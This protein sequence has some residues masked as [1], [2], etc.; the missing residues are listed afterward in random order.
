MSIRTSFF[1]EARRLS[2]EDALPVVYKEVDLRENPDHPDHRFNLTVSPGEVVA[3]IGDEDSGVGDLGK[4]TLG[5]DHPPSGRVVVFGRNMATLSYDDLLLFRRQ[6]G[7]LQVGDGLLQNLTLKDNVALPLRYA[8]DHRMSEVHER[9]EALVR[10]FGL[11][12]DAGL[13]PAQA[14][15]ESRRRA[16]VARAVALDPELLVMEAPFDGLTGRAARALLERATMREDG[17]RRTVVITA[18]DLPPSVTS[19]LDRV[20]R[21]ADGQ[22]VEESA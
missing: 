10:S 21:V 15:E 2:V 13:R 22:A 16:A 19:F 18:Q 8:S 1:A 12:D 6:M 9:V 3:I 4:W 7:Y 17:S 14:N 20:V 11:A 5:L